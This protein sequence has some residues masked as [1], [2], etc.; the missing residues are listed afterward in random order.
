[1]TAISTPPT[2]RRGRVVDLRSLRS[3]SRRKEDPHDP[4]CEIPTTWRRRHRFGSVVVLALALSACSSS[5]R[6][7]PPPRTGDRRPT[8]HYVVA[9]G[10]HKIKHI[11]VIEQENRSF[12]SY[13]GTYPVPTASP[14][15]T[16][17][18]PCAYPFRPVDA[19]R[20]TTTRP[21]SMAW[22]ARRAQCEARRQRGKDDGSSPRPRAAKGCGANV[23]TVDNPECSNSATPDV[24]G[25]H[26]SAEIPNY[27]TYAKDFTLDDHMFE[28]VASW[29]LPTTSTWSQAVSRL[30][31]PAR[32]AARTRS[33]APTRRPRCRST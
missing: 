24:M 6:S 16:D 30:L 4:K 18:L 11:I 13:F 29:S 8:G 33:A 5:P 1:M 17:N 28:P 7:R 10:I 21:T 19:R 2:T 3:P 12:D 26:T 22:P 25:Y 15:R 20:P 9:S 32:R 14:C 27:W 31:E 23:N